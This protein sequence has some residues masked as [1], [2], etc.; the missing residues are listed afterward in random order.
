LYTNTGGVVTKEFCIVKLKDTPHERFLREIS[1]T[2]DYERPSNERY[3]NN[4]YT[5]VGASINTRA[6]SSSRTIPHSDM[7]Y[8]RAALEAKF[9][10]RKFTIK[11]IKELVLEV[12]NKKY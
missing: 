10:D 3:L 6:V 9:P 7:F 4:F 12:Y 5:S 1:C 8:I 11:E 2:D